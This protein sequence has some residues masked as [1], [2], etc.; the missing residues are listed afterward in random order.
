MP[1][2]QIKSIL[3]KK[4]DHSSGVK[5]LITFW[6]VDKL[7]ASTSIHHS[8]LSVICHLLWYV[9]YDTLGSHVVKVSACFSSL[10]SMIFTLNL[11][12]WREQANQMCVIMDILGSIPYKTRLVSQV[13][14]LPLWQL[15]VNE[16]FI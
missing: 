11:I 8:P 15:S 1:A 9:S 13:P 5:N 3:C 12:S 2:D 16:L 14:D 10:S 6:T 4:A 7:Q